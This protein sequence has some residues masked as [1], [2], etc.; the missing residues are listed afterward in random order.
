M[1]D[2]S[3]LKAGDTGFVCV[4]SG[5]SIIGEDVF[6]EENTARE[7][8]KS[9]ISN[10]EEEVVYVIR[11]EVTAIARAQPGVNWEEAK[12]QQL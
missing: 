2:I 11:F 7:D 9:L 5:G 4:S 3:E 12:G 6:D 1:K 8:A 10:E